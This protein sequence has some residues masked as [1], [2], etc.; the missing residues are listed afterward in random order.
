MTMTT[1]HRHT[2]IY[3]DHLHTGEA[4]LAKVQAMPRKWVPLALH[5]ILDGKQGISLLDSEADALLDWCCEQPGW[6][7][8]EGDA[9]HPYPL[10]VD[11]GITLCIYCDAR[12]PWDVEAS[13]DWQEIQ[14]LHS[15]ECEWARSKAHT[16]EVQP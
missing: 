16:I 13:D 9:E 10:C 5:P 3:I 14:A 2:L 8:C 6:T 11:D 7:E 15:Q 4:W 12:V 1:D